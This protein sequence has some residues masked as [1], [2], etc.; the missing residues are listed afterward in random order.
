MTVF[1]F[2]PNLAG[3]HGA[4]AALVTFHDWEKQQRANR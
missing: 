1:V 4:G 2:G 3:I